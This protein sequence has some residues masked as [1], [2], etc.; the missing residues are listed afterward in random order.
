MSTQD[1]F[2][3]KKTMRLKLIRACVLLGIAGVAHAGTE[4]LFTYEV[5]PDG[6]AILDY[7]EDFVGEVV[8]PQFIEGRSVT[9]IAYEA[10]YECGGITSVALPDS[11]KHIEARAF[12]KCFG[13]RTISF[14]RDVATIGEEAFSQCNGMKSI[15]LPNSITAIE[16]K[17]FAG[18][19][20]LAEVF[21]PDNVSTIGDEAFADCK[22]LMSINIPNSVVNIGPSAF[23]DCESLKEV[24]L[25]ASIQILEDNLFGRCGRLKTITLPNG[26]TQIGRWVFEDCTR[27]ERIEIPSSVKSIGQNAFSGTALTGIVIPPNILT[28]DI[29]AFSECEDLSYA[30]F[31]GRP[32]NLESNVFKGVAEAF[33][34]FYSN[35]NSGLFPPNWNG[36]PTYHLAEYALNLPPGSAESA[37]AP[38]ISRVG[39]DLKLSFFGVADG[40]RYSIEESHD[41]KAWTEQNDYDIT[42]PNNDGI[43]TATIPMIPG[44]RFYRVAFTIGE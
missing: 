39:T 32:P 26:L 29:R 23:S 1:P 3:S 42:E 15:E 30:Y 11:V 44:I 34:V 10:F 43:R 41:L 18:C 16:N 8:V 5:S 40:I 33:K 37:Q 19:N 31:M 21:I 27:L 20:L 36:Y 28:I 38:K 9:R 6:V 14:S 22:D 25:S 35:P 4:D 24:H 12:H 7:P 17:T 13:L 2:L